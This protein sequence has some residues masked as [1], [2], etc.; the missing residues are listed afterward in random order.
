MFWMHK[1][2][3]SCWVTTWDAEATL[4]RWDLLQRGFYGGIRRHML[5]SWHRGEHC[6]LRTIGCE[7][8]RRILRIHPTKECPALVGIR[9]DQC[10]A[11]WRRQKRH[12]RWIHNLKN[13]KT[14]RMRD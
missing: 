13:V 10:N 11:G 1:P 5:G 8:K 14:E 2:Y 7:S 3:G 6:F 12:G 9:R 4:H